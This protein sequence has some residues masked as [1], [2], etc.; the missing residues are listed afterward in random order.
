MCLRAVSHKINKQFDKVGNVCIFAVSIDIKSMGKSF[1]C[2]VTACVVACVFFIAAPSCVNNKYEL[3]EENLDMNVTV[4]QEGISLPLGSTADITLKELLAKMELGEDFDKYFG[5]GEDGAYMV[6]I[7]GEYDLSEEL[8]SLTD[9]LD[10]DAVGIDHEAKFSLKDVNLDGLEIDAIDF[11]YEKKLSELITL[12]EVN[13]PS[14][15][16][17]EVN[18]SAGL[19][20]YAIDKSAL[21]KVMKDN[22]ED[23][24]YKESGTL[25]SLSKDKIDKVAPFITDPDMEIQLDNLGS[26]DLGLEKEE[27]YSME[28][29]PINLVFEAELPSGITGISALTFKDASLD[30]TVRLS[31]HFLKSGHVDPTVDL[32]LSHV[33]HL[34]DVAN[35]GH[36]KDTWDHVV[37]LFDLT[38][39]NTEPWS[40][41]HNIGIKSLV[42]ESG[43]VVPENGKVY[44]RKSVHVVPKVTIDYN[45]LV[46][47][48]NLMQDHH[49][50]IVEIDVKF[51]NF[52]VDDI[53]FST[54]PMPMDFNKTISVGSETGID[55]PEQIEKISSIKFTEASKLGLEIVAQNLIDN[56]DL[57]LESLQFTFPEGLD[58]KE[59]TDYTVDNNVVTVPGTAISETPYKLDVMLGGIALGEPEDGKIY[60]KEDIKV[61]AKVKAEAQDISLSDLPSSDADDLK[62]NVKVTPSLEFDDAVLTVKQ[63]GFPIDLSVQS[64]NAELP[65]AVKDMEIVTVYLAGEPKISIDINLPDLSQI[66]GEQVSMNIVPSKEGVALY[67]PEMLK[68]PTSGDHFAYYNHSK[69]ALEYKTRFA[70]IDFPIEKLE[71]APVKEK[72]PVTNTDKAY[73]RG[74][75]KVSGGVSVTGG[76]ITYKQ[77]KK[78]VESE[79][80]VFSFIA[81]M[82]ELTPAEMEFGSYETSA[83]RVEQE[84]D[85]LSDVEVPEMLEQL[86]QIELDDVKLFIDIDARDLPSLGAEA[87]IVFDVTAS[88]PDFVML[89]ENDPR[90]NNN[91]LL[92]S[93]VGTEQNDEIVF[94]MDPVKI[95]GL[96][97]SDVDFKSDEPLDQKVV[98]DASLK[99]SNANVVAANWVDK[100]HSIKLE[101][102]I[103]SDK[104]YAEGEQ[105]KILVKSIKGRVNYAIDPI[106]EEIDL[107]D[108]SKALNGDNLTADIDIHR[109]YVA[110]DVTTN[111]GV[112][113]KAD[114]KITP[115]Y[116][117]EWDEEKSVVPGKAIELS[118]AE[119]A[120]DM[121][122]T[123][124][125]ISNTDEGMP[126][127]YEFVELDLLSLLRNMPEAIKL[128]LAAGT[129]AEEVCVFEPGAEYKLSARYAAGI[130]LELGHDFAIEYRDTIQGIPAELGQIMEYGTLGLGGSVTSSI[131]LNFD[132]SV[133]LLDSEDNLIEMA[134]TSGKQV[135]RGCGPNG[136]PVATPLDIVLEK[137]DG[138]DMSD[139]SSLVLVFVAN[140]ENMVGIPFKE[141]SSL[142]AV[143]NARIPEGI[144]MDLSGLLFPKEDEGSEEDENETNE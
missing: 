113:A 48:L 88:L 14:M 54:D 117:G 118:A 31:D 124:L 57:S 81:R 42:I 140:A 29:S 98:L 101:A 79:N 90:V 94:A 123:S 125:W 138:V 25:I 62:V 102:V 86:Q 56:M 95:I 68:F 139:I 50:A 130:P 37:D 71:I 84:L 33:F 91:T 27:E 105:E 128:N 2:R 119:N 49:Q 16:A 34:A 12:P 39:E 28:D 85:F 70:D 144:T 93:V 6:S 107:S 17:Q 126:A 103:K 30:I 58:V 4:F 69:H 20:D 77:I 127:G 13:L 135:I 75:I 141:E 65:D 143:L 89:D 104:Q 10:I 142:K 22:L 100:E 96:D 116:D 59:G 80:A 99:L 15:P 63:T 18:V 40:Q 41:T 76:E 60:I 8:E 53:V 1:F 61:V 11:P 132:M 133:L 21:N 108:I 87:E 97:L 111:L 114:L 136:T 121:K 110:L 55:V 24:E 32:D 122:T 92:L 9:I 35:D 7:D 64:I 134:E 129:D 115:R 36:D 74:E 5:A 72:D 45:E 52:E 46:T 131:P 106:E 43:D 112:S 83:G 38:H 51:N 109:F 137:K 66:L 3:S 120:A 82:S 67:F 26:M 19:D 78:I 44:L 47:T 23:K 73:A